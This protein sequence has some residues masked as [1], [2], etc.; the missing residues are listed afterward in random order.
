M[1]T[2]TTAFLC[3]SRTEIKLKSL[4]LQAIRVLSRDVDF[5]LLLRAFKDVLT[6]KTFRPKSKPLVRQLMENNVRL[7]WEQNPNSH[8]ISFNSRTYREK[9]FFLEGKDIGYLRERFQSLASIF[10]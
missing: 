6:K 4:R 10:S 8:A 7:Y 1:I 5:Q 9:E 2:S 3:L